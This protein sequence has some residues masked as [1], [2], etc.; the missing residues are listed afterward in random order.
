MSGSYGGFRLWTVAEYHR[1]IEEGILKEIDRVELLEG[2]VVKKLAH[3]LPHDATVQKLN[4]RLVRLAPAGWEVRIQSAVTLT[5]SEPEPD[6]VLASGDE[7]AFDTQ[8]P[9]AS[10]IGLVLEV[11][12]SSLTIDRKDKGR[13]YSCANLPIYWIV[14]VVER[15]IEVYTDPRPSDPVPA[16]ATRTDYMPGDS[17]PLI[18]DGTVIAQI[19][20]SDILA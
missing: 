13:I 9:T 4:K 12:D 8:H 14:N 15:Q 2:Y 10:E 6:A 16:Y 7:S 17:V 20:V 3:S 5:D 1:F 11:S 19:P 18:L